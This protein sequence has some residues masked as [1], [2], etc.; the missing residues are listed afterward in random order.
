MSLS[1]SKP[2]PQVS[3]SRHYSFVGLP[4]G[5]PFTHLNEH[6]LQ[7]SKCRPLES[8]WFR[9]AHSA[10]VSSYPRQASDPF[11]Q[12]RISPQFSST[13]GPEGSDGRTSGSDRLEQPSFLRL[14]RRCR[15]Y[16]FPTF[17]GFRAENLLDSINGDWAAL[18][19]EDGMKG[20]TTGIELIRFIDHTRVRAGAS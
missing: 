4:E 1:F 3:V 10:Q 15:H 5:E 2:H 6:C 16:Q 20:L 19:F 7:R 9:A 18:R 8:F 14:L 13:G 17:S 11:A 12:P